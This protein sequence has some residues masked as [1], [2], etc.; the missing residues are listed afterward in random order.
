MSKEA[1]RPA[2]V[3]HSFFCHAPR[4]LPAPEV[5]LFWNPPSL[6]PYCP[7]VS[8]ETVRSSL[9][10]YSSTRETCNSNIQQVWS[11]SSG[12]TTQILDHPTTLHGGTPKACCTQKSLDSWVQDSGGP[13]NLRQAGFG[14]QH[15]GVLLERFTVFRVW[16]QTIDGFLCVCVLYYELKHVRCSADLYLSLFLLIDS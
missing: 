5:Q 4:E 12:S 7:S 6:N 9:E 1:S 13:E 10:T 14:I 16:M 2:G 3:W 8:A 11:S 15:S